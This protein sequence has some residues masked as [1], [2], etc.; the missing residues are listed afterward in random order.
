M[1]TVHNVNSE[2][3]D[4]PDTAWEMLCLLTRVRSLRRSPD[5]SGFLDSDLFNDIA[6]LTDKLN[7]SL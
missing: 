1:D 2:L 4:H 5:N 7:A 6:A 3:L